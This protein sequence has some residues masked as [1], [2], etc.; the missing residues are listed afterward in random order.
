MEQP[1][2][3][4][5]ARVSREDTFCP[6][7]GAPQLNFDASSQ[8]PGDG[9]ADPQTQGRP[10]QV[11]WKDAIG[12][13]ILVAV[14]AGIICALPLLEM[15]SL[16]WKF[17][18]AALVIFLYKRKRPKAMLTGRSGFRI[19]GLTGL[20]IAY[21][22][23]AVAAI[24]HVVQ[25]FPMHVGKA[26]DSDYENA[27]NQS[28]TVFQTSPET[29]AQ[30]RAMVHFFL[31]PDGRATYSFLGMGYLTVVTILYAALG[32]YVGARLFAGRRLA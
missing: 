22:W 11:F 31:T 19:G 13:A 5:G 14:P 18:A 26:I 1:C 7:C 20:V 15:F 32:G 27:M 17:A 21:V 12:A 16:L 29:Q 2:H 9:N 28:V 10:G 8:E 25:R 4:C 30:M 23:A 6:T 24:I 3:R